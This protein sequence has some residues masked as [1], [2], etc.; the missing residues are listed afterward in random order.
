MSAISFHTEGAKSGNAPTSGKLYFLDLGA[1]NILSAAGE[2]A[3]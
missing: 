3:S 2:S 1:G